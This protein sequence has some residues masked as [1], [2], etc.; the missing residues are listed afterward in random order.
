MGYEVSEFTNSYICKYKYNP[1]EL[2]LW[3]I[4]GKE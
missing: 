3:K 2:I 4:S 1:G